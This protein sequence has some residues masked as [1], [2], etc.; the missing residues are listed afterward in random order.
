MAFHVKA[1]GV[2][3]RDTGNNSVTFINTPAE[4]G[5]NEKSINPKNYLCTFFLTNILHECY[6]HHQNEPHSISLQ[7]W[8]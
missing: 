4:R 5:V 2:E 1:N 6:S 3:I 8:H 7:I